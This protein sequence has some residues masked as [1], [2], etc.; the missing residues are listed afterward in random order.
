MKMAIYVLLAIILVIFIIL[1]IGICLPKA[2]T[3]TKETVYHTSIETVYHTVV[4]NHD[5]K[6]R[7]S[8]DDLKM[9]ETN[10]DLEV[11]D[12]ISNGNIIRFKTKEKRPCSFY[13][14]DMEGK[15]FTGLWF[16]EFETIE[17]GAT[18]FRATESIEYGNPFVKVLAYVFMDLDKYMETYQNEL[19]EKLEK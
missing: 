15:L 18:L 16:A 13:S 9:I 17:N 6:Y 12:E 4:N 1:I 19:R 14:F 7:T 2:R 5:W 11:W 3:L 10:G 8:L